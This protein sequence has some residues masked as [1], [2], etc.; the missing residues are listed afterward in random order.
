MRLV[1]FITHPD[2]VIDP[3]VP[4]PQWSLS[5]RGKERMKALLTKPWMPTIGSVYC[6]TEQKAM[7]GAKILADYLGLAYEMVKDL[8]EIDRSSTGYLPHDQHA[9]TAH[10]FFAYPDRSI[11]GWETAQA[12]QQSIV[13]ALDSLVEKD[14]GSLNIALVSHGAVATLYLCHLKGRQISEKEGQPG[15]S[16]GN[17]YCFEAKSKSLL[18]GWQQIDG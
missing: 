7:D 12:A 17:Y 3:A 8:G 10:K 15:A 13:K 5:E 4:V 14:K 18:H 16:G 9:A 2:V 11:L 1:Y 6:S